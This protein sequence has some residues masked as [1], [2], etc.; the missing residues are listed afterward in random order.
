MPLSNEGIPG[1]RK[2]LAQTKQE[3]DVS[4]LNEITQASEMTPGSRRETATHSKYKG[5]QKM[6]LNTGQ[7]IYTTEQ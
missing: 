3:V 6:R 7:T 1:A 2:K 4:I 5:E